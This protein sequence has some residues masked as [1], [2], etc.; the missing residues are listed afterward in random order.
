[1]LAENAF[2]FY[3]SHLAYRNL[4]FDQ[5]IEK[6][7]AYFYTSKTYQMHV[8]EWQ[9]IVLRNVITNNLQKTVAQYLNIIIEKLQ[10]FHDVLLYNYGSVHSL[11]G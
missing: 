6:T 2:N 11:P 8:N 5:M 7:R 3:Y 9:K 4:L 1:M 10:K